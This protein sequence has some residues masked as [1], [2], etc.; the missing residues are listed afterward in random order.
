MHKSHTVS[1]LLNFCGILICL[2]IVLENIIWMKL[3]KFRYKFLYTLRIVLKST[4]GPMV[5]LD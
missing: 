1:K 5:S 3:T 4:H 2:R